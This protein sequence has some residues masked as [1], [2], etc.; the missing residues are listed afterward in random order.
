MGVGS[1]DE[2]IEDWVKEVRMALVARTTI[3][4]EMNAPKEVIGWFGLRRK[5]GSSLNGT[6]GRWLK[7]PL[8]TC[9]ARVRIEVVRL[10]FVSHGSRWQLAI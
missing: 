5:P 8:V 1:R 2:M 9:G 7:N 10:L 6:L 4:A 3:A